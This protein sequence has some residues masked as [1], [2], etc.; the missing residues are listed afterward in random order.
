MEMVKG[1][2]ECE[3]SPQLLA[4]VSELERQGLNILVLGRKHMLQPSRNWDRQNMNKIKQKS[5]CFFTENMLV[6]P[7]F[8]QSHTEHPVPKLPTQAAI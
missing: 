6:W 4:V 3:L 5:H 1:H 2:W 8:P 7:P